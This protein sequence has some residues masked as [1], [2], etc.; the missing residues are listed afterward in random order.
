MDKFARPSGITDTMRALFER[1]DSVSRSLDE[2][3]A[4]I[5]KPPNPTYETNQHLAELTD[6]ITSLIE[7][8]RQQAALT[9]AIRSS[10][11]LALQYSIQSSK[12]ATI[13]TELASKSVSLTRNAIFVAIII[14]IASFSGSYYLSTSSDVRMKKQVQLLG[15]IADKLEQLKPKSATPLSSTPKPH[16]EP[17]K[18]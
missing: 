2:S 16:T 10:S 1:N 5:Q 12:E 18:P 9:Q 11:D 15:D 8:A 14:A 17:N 6:N 4:A 3:L 13:A 7:V